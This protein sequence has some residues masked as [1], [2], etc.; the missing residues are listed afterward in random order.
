MSLFYVTPT[1]AERPQV[2]P[3]DAWIVTRYRGAQ[4]LTDTAKASVALPSSMAYPRVES[5]AKGE[6]LDSL[7]AVSFSPSPEPLPFAL[8]TR[9]RLM[10]ASGTVLKGTVRIA[11]HRMFRA[12]RKPG[13]LSNEERQWRYG[14]AYLIVIPHQSKR[15]VARL[16]G[17]F[18]IPP[19]AASSS[20][21]GSAIF[22]Q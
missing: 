21:E 10:S 1:V 11:A 22:R 6:V 3:L 13:A 8:P 20:L 4:L 14:H 9:L 17:W 15:P 7:Y 12:P 5:T 19:S 18:L 16:Q 2:D